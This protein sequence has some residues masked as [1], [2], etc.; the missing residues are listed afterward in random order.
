MFIPFFFFSLAIFFIGEKL[1]QK[2]I[3]QEQHKLAAV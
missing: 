3:V 1:Y 2:G